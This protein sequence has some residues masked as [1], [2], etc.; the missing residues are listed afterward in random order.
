V[1]FAQGLPDRLDSEDSDPVAGT[2]RMLNYLAQQSSTAP[3]TLVALTAS[4]SG[5]DAF[6]D[7]WIRSCQPLVELSRTEGIPVTTFW[8]ADL[9][10]R[11]G[12]AAFSIE[13]PAQY[14]TAMRGL[15]SV[16]GG[17]VP[18]YRVSFAVTV[19]SASGVDALAEGNTLYAYPVIRIGERK[20]DVLYPL[21]VVPL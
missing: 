8:D 19:S 10:R 14:R 11:T 21:L 16:V 3:K 20:E 4:G 13:F 5:C 1:P 2:Q 9:A 15:L 7:H 6:T 17:E 12:G 18:F